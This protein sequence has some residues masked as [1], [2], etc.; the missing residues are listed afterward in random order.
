MTRIGQGGHGRPVGLIGTRPRR[1]GVAL[2]MLAIWLV[3]LAAAAQAHGGTAT[4][5][6]PTPRI[7]PGGTLELL[8]D[9]TGE[10]PVDLYLIAS[11]SVVRSLG[12][13]NADADGHFQA[14]IA[15]PRDLPTGSYAVTARS[16][17]DQATSR[18]I[19]D[20]IPV[21]VGDEGQLPGRDDVFAGSGVEPQA[22]PIP[23]LPVVDGTVLGDV[24][25]SDMDLVPFVA[26]ALAIGAL[27][28]LV[29]RTR[30]SP[31]AQA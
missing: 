20:G 4:L 24:G 17:I 11:D 9:M 23:A 13:A 8:G 29:W 26:L 16:A 2:A 6:L 3:A 30:R 28:L 22:T 19:I 1:I 25:S 18:L 31:A 10:G 15:L 5:Q 27:G 14:F 21:P 7:N 12:S